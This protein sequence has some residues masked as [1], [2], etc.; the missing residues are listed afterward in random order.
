MK[1]PSKI[2]M[3]PTCPLLQMTRRH[4]SFAPKAIILQPDYHEKLHYRHLVPL[5]AKLWT[6]L[7]TAKLQFSYIYQVQPIKIQKQKAEKNN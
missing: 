3:K 7:N 4:F 2:G 5:E 1:K 6:L